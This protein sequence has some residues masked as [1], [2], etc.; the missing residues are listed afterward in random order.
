[1]ID[2]GFIRPAH[3][4]ILIARDTLPELIDAMAAYEPHTPITGILS[5]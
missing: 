1:M 5:E 4:G 3:A 2:V